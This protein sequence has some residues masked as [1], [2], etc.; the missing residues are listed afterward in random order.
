MD[1]RNR[2]EVAASFP[3][4]WLHP[5]PTAPSPGLTAGQLRRVQESLGIGE[6]PWALPQSC[7]QKSCK[8]R[9]TSNSLLND[10]KAQN[11]DTFS[12]LISDHY[13]TS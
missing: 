12:L 13:A 4:H 11:W 9:I 7:W 1:L 2:Q 3:S 10:C 6:R 8:V 5:N